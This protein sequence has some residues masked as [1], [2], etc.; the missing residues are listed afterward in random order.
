MP[1]QLKYVAQL[2]MD[3][4]FQQYK[5][6]NDFWELDDFISMCGNT[7]SS[8]YLTFYQQEYSQLRQEK[9]DEVISFDA[10]WLLEQEVEV[11]KNGVGLYA[12]LEKPV[13]TF[14]YDKSSIGLQSIFITEP[15]SVD[16]LE[17]TSLAALWQL[18]Y[19]PKTNRIF[20]YSDVAPTDC[21]SISKVG[22]VNK[23][24]CNIKKIRVLYVPTMN[25]GDANVPDG[26]ISDAVTKT[27]LAMKQIEQGTIIDQT[28]NQNS[29]KIMQ[30][31]IDKAVLNK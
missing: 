14:P 22:F 7:I 20:F 2:A 9:K 10:G 11:K 24:S 25:D 1:Q 8:M 28:E 12:L 30:T 13:M 5:G 27:V 18:K 31:E 23:G 21:M 29:N 15:L 16:E 26:I 3:N 17:R 19:M 6:E 4:F